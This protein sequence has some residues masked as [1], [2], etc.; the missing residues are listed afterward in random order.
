MNAALFMDDPAW[1]DFI[2]DMKSSGQKCVLVPHEDCTPLDP[3]GIA[4]HL[5]P[6]G[7][8]G[9]M[10]GYE[11]RPGQLDMAR[12]VT[13]AFDAAE[14]LMIEAGTGVGKSLAYLLPAMH[15]AATNDTAV[16]VSTATRNLQSQLVSSDIPRALSTLPEPEKFRVALLKGRS[17]YLCLRELQESMRDGYYTL[18]EKERRAYDELVDWLKTTPDGDLDTLPGDTLR[19]RVS[20]GGDDCAGRKCPFHS[21]CFVMKARDRAS[22]AHLVVANHALV[23]SEAVNAAASILPAY[24]R[25]VFDEAHNLEEIATEFFSVEISRAELARVLDRIERR[26]RNRTRGVLGSLDRQLSKGLLRSMAAAESIHEHMQKA[27]VTSAFAVTALDDLLQAAGRIFGPAP[28]AELVRYRVRDGR[29]QYSLHGPFAACLPSHWD[30]DALAAAVTQLEDRLARLVDELDFL[31]EALDSATEPGELPLFG[32]I[33]AQ[34]ASVG[35]DLREFVLSVKFVLGGGDAGHV[36]W[37][38]RIATKS[39]GK[40]ASRSLRLV[41]APLSVAAQMCKHFHSQKDTVVMS[42]ATLRVGSKFDYMARKLGMDLADAGTV[43]MLV[44]ASP[45]DYL[46]QACV[47]A[48]TCLPD[49]AATTTAAV[50]AALAPFL[51]DLFGATR[52]RGLV[53]FTAYD[54]M[55]AV[56]EATRPMLAERGMDL[57]VQ[58]DG[59][60]REAM[61]GRL[62]DAE[63]GRP[64]VLFGAQSF[65]EGVDVAGAALSCVVLARLPFPQ[66]GDPVTEARAEKVAEDGGSAFRDYFLPEA[67]IRF[68]QGFGRLIRS[69]SDRGV[70]VV[71]DARIVQKNYGALF[72]KSI[73][74]SM[75]VVGSAGEALVRA[76]DFLGF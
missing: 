59:L 1:A 68:R 8:L 62:K 4:R 64:V 34:L 17:N 13:R 31:R 73:P 45:F 47:L 57:L 39:R 19:A 71:A 29:R 41:A 6:G 26:T 12:A 20:C 7:T 67:V 25:I 9:T 36:Y 50:A 61:V 76:S 46:R 54:M 10:P 74:G 33:S 27:R 48:P 69:K 23:L 53:L 15:W 40:G 3:D 56:A 65:W 49:P 42:S 28:D 66:V 38:E 14:H 21:K 58:G 72:R 35:A 22:R 43:R 55:R 37:A 63:N 70:V 18:P 32:D 60:S 5:E 24:G 16:V 11:P 52:G 30:E 44:A 75:H 2:P 51:A